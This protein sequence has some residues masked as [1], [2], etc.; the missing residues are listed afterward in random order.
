MIIGLT[1]GIGAGKTTVAALL[2]QKGAFVIDTDLIARDVVEPASPALE[3]I[4]REFG[5][6]IIRPDGSL[7]RHA[8]ARIIFQDESKRAKLNEL[9][10]PEILKRVLAIIGAQ[11]S[12]TIIVA[13]VPL[14]FESGFDRSCD[15]T[16]AVVASPEI[17]R[18]RLQE[19]DGITGSEVE[20]RMKA[21]LPDAEYERRAGVVI[22]NEENLT[23]L[24]REVDR[25]WD[26]LLGA[27][28]P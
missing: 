4:R 10:H 6:G 28:K 8:L 25:A 1:G 22:R 5:D 11:P 12:D 23:A 14:L 24:G 27:A 18:A 17:R 7:D 2:A 9:T 16:L 3:A 26:T 19:R 13:V 20:A 21:Q 15:Q